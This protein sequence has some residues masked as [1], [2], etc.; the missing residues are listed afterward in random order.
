MKIT[1]DYKTDS[2]ALAL[3][4]LRPFSRFALSLPRNDKN[5]Y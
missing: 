3:R 5:Y 4:L 1:L 2:Y